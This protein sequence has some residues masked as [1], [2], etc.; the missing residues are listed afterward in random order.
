MEFEKFQSII[1]TDENKKIDL[2]YREQSIREKL[3]EK[4][5]QETKERKERLHDIQSDM[6]EWMWVKDQKFE[7]KLERE[8]IHLDKLKVKMGVK[9][10]WS[11]AETNTANNVVRNY[12]KTTKPTKLELKK[13]NGNIL[14]RQKFW[15]VFDSTIHQNERLQ[16]LKKLELS[17]KESMKLLLD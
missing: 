15:D 6:E 12:G 3:E 17:K 9:L 16:I 5:E 10:K 2:E 1:D 14:K 11:Y 13:L 7:L 8:R 4:K